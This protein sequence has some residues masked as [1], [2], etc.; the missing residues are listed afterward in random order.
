MVV[1]FLFSQRPDHALKQLISLTPNRGL[2]VF[3]GCDDD[4]QVQFWH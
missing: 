4:H 2:T 3:T 1:Q